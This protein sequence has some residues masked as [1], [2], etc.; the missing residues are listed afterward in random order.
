MSVKVEVELDIFSGNPNPAWILS[1]VD[2]RTFLERV[3]AL[4]V[5]SARELS[6]NLGYRGF[7]VEIS[8]EADNMRVQVQNGIVRVSSSTAEIF[9]TDRNRDL[10]RWL[11]QSGKPFLDSKLLRIV[12]S[13]FQRGIPP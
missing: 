11:L 1:D 9:R 12:E 5:T 10:E 13:E 8:G 3:D 2:G 6:G 4:P 7:V